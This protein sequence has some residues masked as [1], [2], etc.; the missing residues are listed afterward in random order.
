MSDTA[1]YVS[2]IYSKINPAIDLCHSPDSN[3]KLYN[4]ILISETSI[5]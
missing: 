2:L 3:I 4:M 1:C 5:N